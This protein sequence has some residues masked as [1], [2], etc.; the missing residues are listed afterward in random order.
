M[1]AVIQ[2]DEIWVGV[3]PLDMRAGFD[4]ALAHVVNKC[5]LPQLCALW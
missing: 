1:A 3:D 5:G 2:V 4:M